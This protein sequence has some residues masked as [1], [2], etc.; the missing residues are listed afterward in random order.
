MFPW[1][2]LYVFQI[3]IGMVIANYL[4][5]S[6]SIIA[7]MTL[8]TVFATLVVVLW[9]AKPRFSGQVAEGLEL[10]DHAADSDKENLGSA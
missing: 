5:A 6:G 3:A 2:L 8:G 9:I 1:A 7:S 4:Y 10:A